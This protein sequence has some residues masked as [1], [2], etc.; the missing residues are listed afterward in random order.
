MPDEIPT[1]PQ[2]HAKTPE[3]WRPRMARGKRAYYC[4]PCHHAARQARD[5]AKKDGT[6]VRQRPQVDPEKFPCGHPKA[7]ENIKGGNGGCKMCNRLQQAERHAAKR[8]AEGREKRVY[9]P[10]W[11]PCGHPKTP[12]NLTKRRRCRE[13]HAEQNREWWRADPIAR[14]VTAQ[15]WRLRNL[16]RAREYDRQRSL[17]RP[18]TELARL[19]RRARE[20]DLRNPETQEYLAI[21]MK[22]PCVYCGGPVDTRDHIVP[23]SAGGANRWDNYAPACNGCNAA[24]NNRPLLGFLLDRR[25]MFDYREGRTA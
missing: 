23:I 12:E 19:S 25:L 24:K 1:C 10:E 21:V 16:E 8:V 18:D 15:D 22:D 2:G 5:A 3:N 20:Q 4:H 9:D 13:C 14:K 11:F 7:P 6:W 17:L